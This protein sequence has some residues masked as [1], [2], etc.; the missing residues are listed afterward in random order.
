MW[1]SAVTA[2]VS[3]TR[4]ALAGQQ[5]GSGL[6][7]RG[8]ITQGTWDGDLQVFSSTGLEELLLGEVCLG[9]LDK[10]SAP[11]TSGRHTWVLILWSSLSTCFQPQPG[12][13]SWQ[14][15]ARTQS[16]CEVLP[17]EISLPVSDL[18]GMEHPP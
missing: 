4:P 17:L 5:E 7:E 11:L 3:R 2:Y 13:L 16:H 8:A 12:A 18:R 6:G 9:P 15:G 14:T 10:A 1:S